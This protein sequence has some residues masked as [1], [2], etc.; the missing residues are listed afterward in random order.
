MNNVKIRGVIAEDLDACFTV[1]SLCFLPSESASK[2]NIE[3]RIQLFPQGFFVAELD[4]TVIG[5]INS[6]STCKEDITDEEFKAMVGHDDFGKNMVIFSIAVLPEFQR[7]G[8]A[9]QLMIRFI[10]ASKK[11]KKRKIM[12]IC[13]LNF[14]GYYK[15]F[16]FIYIGESA[17][18]HGG[19]KWHEMHFLL[20][21]IAF[22]KEPNSSF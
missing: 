14:I 13:K 16:G 18:T 9:R 22:L 10:E 7:K 2:E 5:H 15:E 3:K 19:F 6:A 17:S 20:E 1:E 4:G 21:E 12:L 8:I 11:L